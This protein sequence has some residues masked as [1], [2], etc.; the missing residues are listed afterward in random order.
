MDLIKEI[1]RRLP[2]NI[3]YEENDVLFE[4]ELCLKLNVDSMYLAYELVYINEAPELVSL[5]WDNPFT[6]E[7][8]VSYLY[9]YENDIKSNSDLSKAIIDCE[10]F[11]KINKLCAE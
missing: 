7:K 4:F 2:S 5:T 1:I 8:E 6:N 10:N 9:M 11:L 3:F